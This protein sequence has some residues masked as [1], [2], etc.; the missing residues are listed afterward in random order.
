[1]TGGVALDPFFPSNEERDEVEL[2]DDLGG[3]SVMPLK[4][5]YFGLI[6]C[7]ISWSYLFP[8][9]SKIMAHFLGFSVPILAFLGGGV[10]GSSAC[11]TGGVELSLR[12]SAAVSSVFF[13][14]TL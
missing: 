5:I 1:V 10:L 12:F 11:A 14:Q 6:F 9:E 3:G 4:M 2:L 13:V 8:D 7:E